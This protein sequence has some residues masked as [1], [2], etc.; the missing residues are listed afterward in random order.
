MI[1]AEW[2]Y[3]IKNKRMIVVLLAIAIIP[4]I[5]CLLYLSSIWN[6][7]SHLDDIPVA[8]V[9]YD[10]S[11]HYNGKDIH[12][13]NKLVHALK[14]SD[15]LDYHNVSASAAKHGLHD[16]K[17]YMSV[18]FPS[19]FSKNATSLLSDHPQQMQ[20]HYRISSGRNFVVAKM[21]AGATS[22]IEQKVSKQVTQMYTTVLLTALKNTSKGMQVAGLANQKV[23]AGETQL[24]AGTTKLTT[25]STQMGTGLTT[26][27]QK[28]P[29]SPTTLPIKQGLTKLGTA[30]TQIT[31]GETKSGL[32]MTKLTAGNTAIATKLLSGSQKLSTIH[33]NNN[34]AYYL[35]NPVKTTLTDEA[36]VPNNGTGMAPFAISL[37]IFVGG[38]GLGTMFDGYKPFKNPKNFFTWWASKASIIA[39]VGVIQSVLLYGTLNKFLGLKT[40][41]N[42][43]LFLLILLG[44]W[45]FLSIIFALKILLGAVGTWLVTIFLVLQISSSTGLYP[46]QLTSNLASNLSPYLPMTYLIDGLRN[47]ISLGGGIRYDVILLTIFIAVANIIVIFKFALDIRRAKFAFLDDPDNN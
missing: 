4:A 3:L 10:K 31:A 42:P 39:T 14:K 12:I 11:V 24:Q 23:A 29:A 35:A 43:R 47:A 13:G 5:Y 1:K 32:A 9:N 28:I 44:A 15:S 16:G 20:I 40:Q 37:G 27:Q 26:M 18:T 6:T 7:Y 33:A 21:T 36:K 2:Q 17:Y 34:N 41:S 19:N 8:V 30:N 38:I 46:I 25:G 22:A 45:A